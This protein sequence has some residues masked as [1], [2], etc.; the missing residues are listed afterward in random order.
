MVAMLTYRSSESFDTRFGR[1]PPRQKQAPI[2][3]PLDLPR[4]STSV[5]SSPASGSPAMAKTRRGRRDPSFSAQGYLHYQGQKFVQRFDANCYLHLTE[6]MDRHDIM[7]GRVEEAAEESDVAA[8]GNDGALRKLL[9]RVAPGALVVSVETDALFL[10]QQ[11]ERLAACLPEATLAVLK[12][13]DGHDGFLLEFEQLNS[14]ITKKLKS[15]FPRFYETVSGSC[16]DGD[17][18]G[19]TGGSLTGEIEA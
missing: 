16:Q 2:E 17:F 11:Q 18:L 13:T 5:A 9:A 7:V 14:L 15:D 19:L 8:P 3:P 12:S 10:P 6:K 4:A 1:N